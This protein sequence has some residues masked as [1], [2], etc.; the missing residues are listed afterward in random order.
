MANIVIGQVRLPTD[1][2]FEYTKD[3][4]ENND[5]WNLHYS[6]DN[7]NVFTK[8]SPNT[9]FEIMKIVVEYSDVSASL[10]Y[11]MFQDEEYRFEWDKEMVEGL[12]WPSFILL[13]NTS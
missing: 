3:F 12:S 13:R 5:G 6:K 11:E 7:I 9:L 2:D 10:L 1:E 8:Q 4:C